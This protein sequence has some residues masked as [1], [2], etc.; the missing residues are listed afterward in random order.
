MSRDTHTTHIAMSA[1][2]VG[3]AGGRTQR[4]STVLLRNI[5]GTQ[6]HNRNF[7]GLK[8]KDRIFTNLYGEHDW[9]LKGAL[10][11]VNQS[12]CVEY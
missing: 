2:L 4:A 10:K 1:V 7:G 9:T 12:E 11:R 5:I 3:A 8:D 6:Q